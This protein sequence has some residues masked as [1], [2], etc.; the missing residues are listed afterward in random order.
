M[1]LKK[2][3][4]SQ[5]LSQNYR[6][7]KRLV[8]SGL[9]QKGKC[10]F[11]LIELLVVITIIAILAAML[12]PALREARE[13]ARQVV[14]ISNLK[15]IGLAIM[16]YADDYD[17]YIPPALDRQV[18]DPGRGAWA[19]LRNGGYLKSKSKLYD[20]PSDTTREPG[21]S[22]FTSGDYGYHNNFFKSNISYIYSYQAGYRD[23]TGGWIYKPVKLSM[24]RKPTKDYIVCD[25]ETS[26]VG[27]W[28][29]YY[30]VGYFT[31]AFDE[32]DPRLYG[33]RH[34]GGSNVLF[35]DGHM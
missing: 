10:G 5:G 33:C 26:K 11:T 32:A 23:S 18:P 31:D 27:T 8:D 12:L 9:S 24:I 4:S 35:M 6:G 3:G 2:R 30:G 25:G 20:C 19:K 1:Q 29:Y 7:A 13:K 15:Q 16:M 21:P 34:S 22:P 14:C 28:T 17:E